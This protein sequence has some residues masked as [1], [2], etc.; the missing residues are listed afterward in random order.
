MEVDSLYTLRY[1]KRMSN[2]QRILEV[3]LTLF[4]QRGYEATSVQEICDQVEIT[5]PTLYHY[6]GSKQGLLERSGFLSD[7]LEISDL[8]S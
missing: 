6:Y 5:K 4:A 1:T 7:H 2:K 3:G 8:W